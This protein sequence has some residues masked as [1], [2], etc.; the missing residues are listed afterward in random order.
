[1]GNVEFQPLASSTRRLLDALGFLGAPLDEKDN[2]GILAI[3]DFPNMENAVEKI[4]KL[5]D[6]YCLATG[7]KISLLMVG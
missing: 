1:M 6:P 3:L 7:V 5:L 2:A 4:Q